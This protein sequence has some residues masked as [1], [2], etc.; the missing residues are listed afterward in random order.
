M[1]TPIELA[2]AKAAL[3]LL[4]TYIA[5]AGLIGAIALSAES[6]EMRKKRRTGSRFTSCTAFVLACLFWPRTIRD[7]IRAYFPDSNRPQA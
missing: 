7:T 5:I 2:I 1:R 4:G 6:P 3:P